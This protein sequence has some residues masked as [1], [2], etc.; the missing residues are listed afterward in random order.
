MPSREFLHEVGNLNAK[1]VFTWTGCIE[2]DAKSTLI[3]RVVSEK[4]KDFP[5]SSKHMHSKLWLQTSNL[6]VTVREEGTSTGLKN[7]PN[8]LILVPPFELL[9]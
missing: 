9:I 3:I 5:Y 8:K 1:L 6:T 7:K 2:R 4:S